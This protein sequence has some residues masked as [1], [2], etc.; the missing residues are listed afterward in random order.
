MDQTTTTTP[1]TPGQKRRR[2]IRRSVVIRTILRVIFFVM[3]PGA[4]TAGFS[5]VKFIFQS[6]GK[7]QPLS[8]NAFIGALIGLCVFT[9]VF[10]RFFCGYACAF[11]SFGDLIYWLSG[12]I[13]KKVFRRKKQI[14]LPARL[15]PA[16]Q[17]IKYF[18][19][20]AITVLC[21]LGLWER[22]GRWSPWSVFSLL[23]SGRF[24]L[25]GYWPGA[26]VLLLIVIG[27]AFRERFFCQFLCPMG[28]VFAL[29]PSFTLRRRPDKCAPGCT[30]CR[31]GC[32]VSIRLEPDGPANGEC[33]GCQR[34]AVG[35]PRG[36]LTSWDRRVLRNET[37]AA[38]V[39][40]GLFFVMG[41][42]LGLCRFL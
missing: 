40:G 4:F 23:L 27:M 22:L 24:S 34:C 21:V 13:Q 28:A 36:S 20:A 38:L 5:G 9:V 29:L 15:V 6:I 25:D 35:C 42:A 41:A 18:V 39:K 30:V 14:C 16:G 12:L 33:I 10:G 32:P 17:K 31:Q 3:M 19:L 37:A 8:W 7:G 11:G 1:L 26:A 2:R